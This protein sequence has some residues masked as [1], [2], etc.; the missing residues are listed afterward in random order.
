MIKIIPRTRNLD[1]MQI[2]ETIEPII[3]GKRRANS[4][5]PTIELVTKRVFLGPKKVGGVNVDYSINTLYFRF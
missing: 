5:S 1:E 3:Y 2:E 4:A